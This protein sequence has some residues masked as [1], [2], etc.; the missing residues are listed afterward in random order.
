[1]EI[2]PGTMSLAEMR[3]LFETGG[4]VTLPDTAWEAVDA[5]AATV[6]NA[7]AGDRT[8]Y[9]VNTGFGRLAQQA[10]PRDQ[11][12][13]LQRNLL[14]SHAV[15]V[16]ADL[17]DQTARLVIGLKVNSLAFDDNPAHL[18]LHMPSLAL[19]R[20]DR[21]SSGAAAKRRHRLGR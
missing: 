1:M 5:A 16:G 15:G 8:V 4:A 7:L 21:P 20:S 2:H 13:Q 12:A 14:L 6:A 11:L 19:F 3:S 9:G 17:D 18:A 10:I